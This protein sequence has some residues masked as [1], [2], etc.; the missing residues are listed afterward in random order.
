MQITYEYVY[1]NLQDAIQRTLFFPLKEELIEELRYT[2]DKAVDTH[3]IDTVP[4]IPLILFGYD[5]SINV[6]K[7]IGLVVP[8]SDLTLLNIPLEQHESNRPE[9]TFCCV[10]CIRYTSENLL[11]VTRLFGDGWSFLGF[12]KEDPIEVAFR[13]YQGFNLI[14]L[15]GHLIENDVNMKLNSGGWNALHLAC[16]FYKG[17]QMI[18]IVTFLINSGIDLKARVHG[19]HNANALHT[20]CFF[21]SGVHFKEIIELL[22]KNGINPIEKATE[23]WNVL[24]LV[25]RHYTGP[26]M[27]EIIQLLISY[28]INVNEKLERK[29]MNALHFLCQHYTG[30]DLIEIIDLFIQNGIDVKATDDEGWNGL[31]FV[32]AFYY[33]FATNLK[34]IIDLF[35][36][37]GIDPCAKDYRGWQ[38]LHILCRFYNRED[39]KD[40][41]VSLVKRK[42]DLNA[43]TFEFTSAFYFLCRNYTRSNL[44]E[45]VH[46]FYDNGFRMERVEFEWAA[47]VQV[48]FV[49]RGPSEELFEI[50]RRIT[51]EIM[52]RDK[53]NAKTYIDQALEMLKEFNLDLDRKE[54]IDY[55]KL[56]SEEA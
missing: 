24:H 17:N 40:I 22:V 35:I 7:A 12:M 1:I 33:K 19:M 34:D 37:N 45:I 14:E 2:M 25:C 26:N 15:V 6:P 54:I 31:H 48:C 13:Y 46:L 5:E 27:K 28:G 44:K 3:L 43:L 10:F 30:T 9:S 23:G 18:D 50:V 32:C 38:V 8:I 42:V 20:L 47:L 53:M 21:Y 51:E 16:R 41:I 55:L 36:R 4:T 52:Q 39:L 11:A 29:S 49:N 56:V